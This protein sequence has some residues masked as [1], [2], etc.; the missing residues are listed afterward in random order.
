MKKA[1]LLG[2]ILLSGCA[3]DGYFAHKDTSGFQP[4]VCANIPIGIEGFQYLDPSL[5]HK[6]ISC[7]DL[8][9][10]GA[11]YALPAPPN[12]PCE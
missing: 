8:A 6:K 11:L 2:L 12:V 4:N 1:I 9:R 10:C 3:G 5:K 7:A